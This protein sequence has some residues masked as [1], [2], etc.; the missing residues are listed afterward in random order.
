M[1]IV[2]VPGVALAA[3]F[4]VKVAAAL[5]PDGTEIGLGLKTEKVTPAG[6]EPV[7]ESVTGPEK[8]SWELPVI[9]MPADAP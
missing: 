8:P 6:T 2:L 9:V 3:T 1:V 5:P 4:T 7:T